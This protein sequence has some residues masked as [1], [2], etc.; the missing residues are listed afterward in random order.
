MLSVA[1][2][3]RLGEAGGR[4][5]QRP[6]QTLCA[7]NGPP[8]S[9]PLDRLHFP[10][11]ETFAD[12]GGWVGQLAGSRM[13]PPPS[14]TSKGVSIPFW[15]AWSLAP[16]SPPGDQTRDVVVMGVMCY[17]WGGQV[18]NSGGGGGG[19]EPP[20]TGGRGLGKGLR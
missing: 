3:L 19:I 5:V 15:L 14:V 6:K 8:I 13:P 2:T 9:G 11:E 1:G 7:K 17:H 16:Y 12:V 4:G 18:F 10:P 20:K